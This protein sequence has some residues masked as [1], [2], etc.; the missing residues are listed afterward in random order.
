MLDSTCDYVDYVLPTITGGSDRYA[1]L[2]LLVRYGLWHVYS[3]KRTSPK[4]CLLFTLLQV[5]RE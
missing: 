5:Q 2:C 1:V 3:F 4:G